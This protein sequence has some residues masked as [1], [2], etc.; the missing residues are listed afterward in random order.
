MVFVGDMKFI[1]IGFCEYCQLK[2]E[3][4]GHGLDLLKGY[5]VV[6]VCN[7]HRLNITELDKKRSI[8]R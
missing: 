6:Q 3:Y 7:Q 5:K 2:S 4:I 8:E 1:Q